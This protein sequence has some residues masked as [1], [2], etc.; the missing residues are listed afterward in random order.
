MG[1]EW[2]IK[3]ADES[4]DGVEWRLTGLQAEHDAMLVPG[5]ALV[6]RLI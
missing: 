5:S 1:P 3:A 6:Y 4:R 2:L